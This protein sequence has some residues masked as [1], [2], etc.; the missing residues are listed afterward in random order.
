[1]ADDFR[2]DELAEGV[3]DEEPLLLL[4]EFLDVGL[5]AVVVVVV[6]VEAGETE[7]EV[8]DLGLEGGAREE[9]DWEELVWRLGG[10]V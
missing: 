5:A 6:L 2:A 3:L 8:A 4:A 9:A 10:I 1:M 7:D